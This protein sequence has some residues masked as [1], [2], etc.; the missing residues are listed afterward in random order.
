MNE[1]RKRFHQELD[2][3]STE[4]VGAG[5]L[6]E[7]AVGAATAALATSDQQAA[8]D[9]I[10]GDLEIDHRYLDIEHRV[11]VSLARQAP[12]AADLRLVSAVMHMNRYIERIGDQAVNIAKSAQLAVDLPTDAVILSQLGEMSDRVRAMVR[13]GIQAFEHR[14]L[15]QALKLP[16][17]DD[18]VDLLNRNMYEEVV[19]LASNPA[20]LKWGILMNVVARHL[21][22]VGDNAVNIGAQ[23]GFLLTGEFPEFAGARDL[24]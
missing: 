6:A 10:D 21:E 8:Q 24:T 3:L 14:D 20:Q 7:R 4:I 13:A 22:R 19:R 23:V 5:Q 1:T 15:E 17:M 12:V 16:E 11:F 18:P 9:V 2:D